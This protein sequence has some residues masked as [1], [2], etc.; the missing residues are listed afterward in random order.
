MY[1]RVCVYAIAR[2]TV[3]FSY[4][5]YSYSRFSLLLLLLLSFNSLCF[6]VYS[7]FRFLFIVNCF[8]LHMPFTFVLFIL[9]KKNIDRSVAF[10][11]LKRQKTAN[12]WI[13]RFYLRKTDVWL[14]QSR[15][16]ERER[17]AN[18]TGVETQGESDGP[19]IN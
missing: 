3:H 16:R 1:V 12:K 17:E 6:E 11:L 2:C 8:S 7:L 19:W 5:Q 9:L 13:K 10:L 15:E 14:C 18:C 4:V